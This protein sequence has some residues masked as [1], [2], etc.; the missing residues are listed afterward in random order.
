LETFPLPPDVSV[1]LVNWNTRQLLERCLACLVEQLQGMNYDL[2]VVDNASTDDS[3]SMLNTRFPSVHLIANTTNVGFA[4][5]NNQAMQ[6]AP[7]RYFLLIN[8]DAF[9]EPGAIQALYRLAE[10]QGSVGIAG[11]HLLNPDGSFQGSYASFPNLWQEFLMLTGLG[12]FFC[13]SFYPNY[14]PKP[15]EKAKPVNY[16]QGACLF[17][18]RKAYEQVG[19]LDERYF[20]Y[21]EEVD[22][23]YAMQKA[24]WE[25]WYQ[26]DACVV[27]IGGASSSG[28]KVQR[29]ADLYLSRVRFFQK[30]Y[31]NFSTELLKAML[32]GIT[33]VKYVVHSILKLI[34]R[35]R[36]G[37]KVVSPARL[38][39]EFMKLPQ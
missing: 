15:E 4:A 7:G 12:R 39:Q 5:A 27:H 36:L 19:G 13:G 22:W 31:G 37:R 18:N 21:S 9:P 1:I 24:G 14:A 10:E 23:C 30:N 26:P 8:T 17:V 28:R 20:M 6:K 3:I 25:V 32:L 33:S 16:V 38:Y 29:E 34:S 11:A 2:W 35:Q